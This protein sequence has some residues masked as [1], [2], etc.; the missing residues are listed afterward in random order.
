M[1]FAAAPAAAQP[2]FTDGVLPNGVPSGASGSNVVESGPKFFDPASGDYRPDKPAGSPLVDLAGSDAPLGGRLLNGQTQTAGGWDAG[3]LES[4]GAALPVELSG[5]SATTDGGVVRLTWSTA[6]ES[7]NARFR[8]QRH[9]GN[10]APDGKNAWTTIGSVEGAGT[11]TEPQQY[12]F[13]DASPPFSADRL[14]YRLVQVDIGGS[15][16]PSDPVVVDL[17]APAEARLW[18]PSPNPARAQAT[19]R[20]SLPEKPKGMRTKG[21]RPGGKDLEGADPRL[22]V[23]DMLGRHVTTRRLTGALGSRHVVR[24]DVS[25]WP[26]GPY[27]VRLHVG[28]VTHTE[29]LTVVR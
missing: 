1:S 27:V 28:Q 6:S 26:S 21:T 25:E 19:V 17:R 18:P 7:G 15:T 12:R 10:Q 14:R 2:T 29:R 9:A 20:V 4:N 22:T 3:A 24:L 16:T 5:F 8:V 13:S 11:T 23:F